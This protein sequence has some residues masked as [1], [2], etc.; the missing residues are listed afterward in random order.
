MSHPKNIC[1]DGIFIYCDDSGGGPLWE[2]PREEAVQLFRRWLN[3]SKREHLEAM[4]CL[5]EKLEAAERKDAE[6]WKKAQRRL[7]VW[8]A[9]QAKVVLAKAR[10]S[11]TGANHD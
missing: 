4:R 8:R 2:L 6:L 9:Q 5:A 3:D 11:A 7:S 1:C 10:A